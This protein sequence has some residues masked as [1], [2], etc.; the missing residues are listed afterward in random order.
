[1]AD[2][3]DSRSMGPRSRDGAGTEID[4]RV[5]SAKAYESPIKQRPWVRAFLRASGIASSQ[6]APRRENMG[7]YSSSTLSNRS[8]SPRNDLNPRSNVVI[9]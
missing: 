2:I 8:L 1:M 4:L 6:T 3:V 5:P 7:D 9:S